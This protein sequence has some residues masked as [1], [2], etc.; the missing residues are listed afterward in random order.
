MKRNYFNVVVPKEYEVIENGQ[1]EKRTFWNK[2]GQ[3]WHSKS[4]DALHVELFL[5]PGQRYLI[6]LK[7]RKPESD[8]E[9][10][11]DVPF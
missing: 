11:Q 6:S 4:G 3:A 2:V 7:D 8:F 10:F 1:T 5:L 9:S